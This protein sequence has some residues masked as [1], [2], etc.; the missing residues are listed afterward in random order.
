MPGFTIG[1]GEA[2]KPVGPL[3]KELEVMGEH[4]YLLHAHPVWVIRMPVGDQISPLICRV[5]TCC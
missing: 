2:I 1:K 3:V 4:D 5:G